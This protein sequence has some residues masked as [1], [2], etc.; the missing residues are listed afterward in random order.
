MALRN[1]G[2]SNIYNSL[3]LAERLFLFYQNRLSNTF[4]YTFLTYIYLKYGT[5]CVFAYHLCA[6]AMLI[7][8]VAF[9]F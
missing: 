4:K 7:F 8:S 9:Q 3:K 1:S 6:G 2:N 5:L